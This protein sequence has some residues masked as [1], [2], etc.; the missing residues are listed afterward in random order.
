M[1]LNVEQVT[2]ISK[3]KLILESIIILGFRARTDGGIFSNQCN[4]AASALISAQRDS[5]GSKCHNRRDRVSQN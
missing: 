5:F 4:V 3:S 1:Y 2:K